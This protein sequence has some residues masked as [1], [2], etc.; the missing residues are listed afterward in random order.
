MRGPADQEQEASD[1][2]EGRV[3]EE[4]EKEE[5]TQEP[6][7]PPTKYV[8]EPRPEPS[9][10]ET[11]RPGPD[12]GRPAG[13]NPAGVHAAEHGQVA[14]HGTLHVSSRRWPPQLLAGP[15]PGV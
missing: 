10:T 5:R 7:H 4:E 2:R 9:R 15:P 8:V 11:D 12:L 6:P 3:E 13:W 1:Q 14:L